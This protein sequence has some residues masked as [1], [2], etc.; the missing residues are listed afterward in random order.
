MQGVSIITARLKLN[1]DPIK[2]LSEISS[3]VDQVR[4]NLPPR[5]RFPPSTSSPP[6]RS[7]RR[8]T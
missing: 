2:A 4:S 7:S 3:K 6:T 5:P 1:Y 8:P